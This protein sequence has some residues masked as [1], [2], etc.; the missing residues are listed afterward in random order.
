MTLQMPRDPAALYGEW[1]RWLPS[2]RGAFAFDAL[3]GTPFHLGAS[4]PLDV[5]YGPFDYV[6]PAARLALV[7]ITPG[8]RETALAYRVAREALGQGLEGSEIARQVKTT[9][10]FGGPTRPHLVAMLDGIGVQ[11][12]LGLA[13]TALLFMPRHAHLL[14]ATA[15]VRY[16]VQRG[17]QD[18]AGTAPRLARHPGLLRFVDTYLAPELALLDRALVVPLGTSVEEVLRLLVARGA[19]DPCRCLFGF[20]HPSGRNVARA[21]QFAARQPALRRLVAAWHSA[22]T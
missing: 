7:G 14:H 10:S 18:Y 22:Y 4:G 8:R 13:T 17:G 20:P 3:R 12:A 6:S 11:A 16:P 1:L 15:A 2:W 19:L 9:A 21:A 5:Y